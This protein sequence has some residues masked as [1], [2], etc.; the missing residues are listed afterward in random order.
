MARMPAR[1]GSGRVGQA[2]MTSASSGV[3][4]ECPKGRERDGRSLMEM[5]FYEKPT[6][7]V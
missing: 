7:L 3:D 4:S 6:F 5:I 1:I 2:S